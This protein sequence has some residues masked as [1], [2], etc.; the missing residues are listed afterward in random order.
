MLDLKEAHIENKALIAEHISQMI[1]DAQNRE[2]A[3]SEVD[4]YFRNHLYTLYQIFYNQNAIGSSV[5]KKECFEGSEKVSEIVFLYIQEDHREQGI[6]SGSVQKIEQDLMQ[7]GMEK[8][9]VKVNVNNIKAAVF[10][11]KNDYQFESRLLKLNGNEDY[12]LLGKIM[13]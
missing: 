8:V 12:Y 9:Y 3:E 6:G 2:V 5:I 13:K 7:E 4:K 1:G 10:W 11:L